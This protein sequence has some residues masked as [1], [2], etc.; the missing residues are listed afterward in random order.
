MAESGPSL[1]TGTYIIETFGARLIK[2]FR[3][4]FL[5]FGCKVT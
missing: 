2:L 4:Y 1:I 5:V 3:E